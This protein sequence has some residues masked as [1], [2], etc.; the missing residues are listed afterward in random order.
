MLDKMIRMRLNDAD[1]L[2][3]HEDTA[4]IYRQIAR[5]RAS[6]HYIMSSNA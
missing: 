2:N 4:E 6:Y 3:Q 1:N 5:D